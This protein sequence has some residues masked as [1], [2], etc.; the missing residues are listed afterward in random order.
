MKLVITA[1]IR[2]SAERHAAG[3]Q[4]SWSRLHG[5]E[6]LTALNGERGL[7]RDVPQRTAAD[8]MHSPMIAAA[9]ITDIRRIA[10]GRMESGQSQ[11]SIIDEAGA[12]AGF[13][14]C[15]DIPSPPTR[16]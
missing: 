11:G 6:L 12:L 16:P 7:L 3:G 14:P 8:V 10:R 2:S 15:G 1:G 9:P 5:R 4:T 13:V